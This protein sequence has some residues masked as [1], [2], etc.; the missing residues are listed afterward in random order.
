MAGD[1]SNSGLTRRRV[2]LGGGGALGL[3]V[4][5]GAGYAAGE[6][7]GSDEAS[8]GG[9]TVAFH[10]AH[11]AGV[12]TPAQA[13]LVF[14]AFDLVSDDKRDLQE[15]LR[16]WTANARLMTAG[17]PTGT[18]AGEVEVPPR[19]TGEAEGLPASRLTITG[20]RPM[21]VVRKI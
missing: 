21:R 14:G 9:E 13:R 15:L 18:V 12:A 5:A 1:S 7:T 4:A 19:D 17:R 11:Q 6:S 8:A 10:G 20:W 16:I 3:A 2:L